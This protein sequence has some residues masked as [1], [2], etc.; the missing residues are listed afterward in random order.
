[1][2]ERTRKAP[3]HGSFDVEKQPVSWV[4][5]GAVD[6]GQP[7]VLL[8]HGAGAPLTS[9]FMAAVAAGLA[10]RELAVVRFHFPYMERRVR[11]NRSGG[12]PDRPPLLLATWRRMASEAES[13]FATPPR[14]I[15]AGKSMGGRIASMLLASDPPAAARGAVY[16]GYPL[17]PAGR[18]EVERSSHLP[19]VRVPQLFVSGTRDP[20]GPLERLRPVVTS[21]G[22][23]ARLHVVDKGDHSLA[24]SRKDPLAGSD[25]WLD[26]VAQFVREVCA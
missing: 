19:A 14:L 22:A 24:T 21:L 12:A 3:D 7:L 4:R 5:D 18:P 16:L 8:A 2:V 15:L 25:A 10:A 11:Q 9:P 20:L 26:E 17:C 13:W 1:M 6:A 23:N